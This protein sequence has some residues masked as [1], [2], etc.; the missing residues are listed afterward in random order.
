M[1]APR[2]PNELVHRLKQ[3]GDEETVRHFVE[4]YGPRLLAAATL[5]SGNTTDAQDLMIDTLQH[6][7]RAIHSFREESSFF[8]WLYGILFNLNRAVWRKR[9]RHP[10]L[11]TDTLPDVPAEGPAVGSGLDAAATADG[12]AAAIRQLSEPLQAVVLLRYYGE[13]SI[14]E[15]AET[16]KISPGTV[17]SRLFSATR[18]LRE[19]LPEELR[20]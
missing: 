13:M 1:K 2:A 5:L 14:A 19:L 7:V 20:P 15:V 11:Y 16:L 3:G 8:S 6:A 17:K 18:K 9:S 12:L 10:W 4:R